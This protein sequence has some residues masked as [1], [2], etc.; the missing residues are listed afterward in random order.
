[1][2][3]HQLLDNITHKALR[4]RHDYRPGLGF[5]DNVARVF[6]GEFI[7]LQHEYPLFFIK[8]GQTEDF[9]AIALLGFNEQENLY[10]DDGRW[11]ANYLPL[12]VERQPFLIGM[13][14]QDQDGVPT[15]TPVVHIDMDHPSVNEAEGAAVFLEHGGE[16]PFLER[17]SAV[18]N[19]I[20]H[21]HETSRSMS[22]VLV[23]LEL[24]ESMQL[25]VSFNDGSSQSLKGLY[26][27]NEDKLRA[28]NANALGVLHDDN[29]LQAVYMM[30]A[31]LANIS[32]LVARRNRRLG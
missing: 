15:E 24:I 14:Q 1:M 19:A 32:D 18:L 26:T 25:D 30:L 31:S 8:N 28:L 16:S 3:N 13:Q 17:I 4:I 5:D 27:I 12:S 11:D 2:S 7:Q 29:Y 21:G 9:E 6:P 23:G 10:L 20:H 22:Q